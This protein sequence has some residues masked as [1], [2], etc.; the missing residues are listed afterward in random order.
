MGGAV[1]GF[2]GGQMAGQVS[3][4][5]VSMVLELLMDINITIMKCS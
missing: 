5:S 1:R 3:R 2:E 4:G